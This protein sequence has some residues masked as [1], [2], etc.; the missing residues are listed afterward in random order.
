MQQDDG[1]LSVTVR[2]P[3]FDSQAMAGCSMLGVLCF[4]GFFFLIFF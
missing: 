3:V 1:E 4:V 2:T